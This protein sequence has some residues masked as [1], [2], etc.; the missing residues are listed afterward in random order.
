M[1]GQDR[2]CKVCEPEQGVRTQA[3]RGHGD[4][5]Q[6]GLV[7]RTPIRLQPLTRAKVASLGAAGTEWEASLPGL[8]VDR[9]RAWSLTIG[10]P[11]TG[12][13]ASYVVRV[14][15]EHGEPAVL[16]LSIPD[17]QTGRQVETLRRANGRGYARLLAADVGQGAILMESLGSSLD[18]SGAAPEQQLAVLAETLQRAWMPAIDDDGPAVGQDKASLLAIAITEFRAALGPVCPDA[19]VARALAYADRLRHV[20]PAELRLVHGDPHPANLLEIELPR[21][22][23]ETGWAFVDPDGFVAD[24]AYDLGVAVRDWCSRIT[25]DQGIATIR[26]Y[27]AVLAE[28]TGVDAQR[29][30]AWGYL[31]RVSTGLYVT[32]FGAERLGRQFLDS[33]ALLLE[34][35][36]AG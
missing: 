33:A 34:P 17:E 28:R 5:Q 2:L 8:L 12:G 13:S 22:G 26:G 6:G 7:T 36:D 35:G 18:R 29:I 21:P 16:K 27:C 3:G 30:W 15:T 4:P 24:R 20:E 11:L 9:A 10:K 1:K 32:S 31:E 19:V 14:T 25:P 23:G